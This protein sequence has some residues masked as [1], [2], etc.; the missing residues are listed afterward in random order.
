MT[1]SARQG[2][3]APRRIDAAIV[4]VQRCGTTSLAALL[5]EHPQ[6]CLAVGKEAHLFDDPLVQRDG[7][8]PVRFDGLFPHRRAGQLLLDATPS[9]VYLPGCIEALVAHNPQVKLIVI[10][11]PAAERAVS[12]HDLERR[13][14]T[15]H[16]PVVFALA[17]ERWR[18]WRDG[19]Q[20][21]VDSA[22]RVSSYL[23]RGRY[24]AQLGHLRSVTEQVHVVSLAQLVAEPD[25][26][27][28]G[29]QHFLGVEPRPL[30]ALPRLNAGMARPAYLT[31]RLLERTTRAEMRRSEML[32]GWPA[33][34]L[35]STP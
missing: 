28:S 2:D 4:G 8:A 7:I 35:Q 23:D 24:V 29:V 19:D 25:S 33:G 30:G 6:I 22:H 18:L 26:V 31:R 3:D 17:L 21:A 27:L 10:L 14:G 13:R 34:S 11:R 15:E 20:L 32:L 9:Y 1:G 12:H 5:G 16:C